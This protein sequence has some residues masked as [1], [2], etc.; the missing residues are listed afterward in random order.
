M[1]FYSNSCLTTKQD[2][3]HHRQ[4]QLMMSRKLDGGRFDEPTGL[5]PWQFL[6][7]VYQ[8][9]QL[10]LLMFPR[11]ACPVGAQTPPRCEVE[12]PWRWFC[13]S[14]FLQQMQRFVINVNGLVHFSCLRERKSVLYCCYSQL[15]YNVL[16][17]PIKYQFKHKLPT[18]YGSTWGRLC[19]HLCDSVQ[20]RKGVGYILSRPV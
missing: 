1:P 12:S 8:H 9:C 16:Q 5:I 11:N 20:G 15:Y 2:L 13:H 4:S 6:R 10:P 19:F 17:M 18:T 3:I 14:Y 7:T